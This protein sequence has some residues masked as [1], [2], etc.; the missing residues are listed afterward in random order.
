MASE[1]I[2]IGS[3]R[4]VAKLGTGAFGQV[5]LA[6]H[7][8][9]TNRT[10]AIK[11][12]HLE[13]LSSPAAII[14]FI[15]EAQILEKLKHPHILPIINIDIFEGIPYLVTEFASKGSLRDCLQ[16]Y[17]QHY[18]SLEEAI[19]IL[20]QI[21]EALQYAHQQNI[22][23]RDIKPEN[24]LFNEKGEAL[25]ADFGIATTLATASIKQTTVTGT[26][27]Y[28]AP[29]QF[30]EL[31][32]KESDQYALGCIAYELFTGHMPFVASSPA[33]LITKCLM[34]Q[35]VAPRQYNPQ[36]PG[37]IEQAILKAMA[38][39]RTDRY[40]DISRFIKALSP[41]GL[42]QESRVEWI[43]K[44]TTLAMIPDQQEQIIAV[45]NEAIQLDP[46]FADAYFCKGVALNDLKRH[47]E[48]L[49]A[50]ERA[51]HLDPNNK[52]AWLYKGDLLKYLGRF[53][54]ARQAYK[55]AQRIIDYS[56]DNE[57]TS[58]TRS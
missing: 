5:Y 12:M 58:S 54:D 31:V 1:D 32:C 33:A 43:M 3:Y 49:A 45:C 42:S 57:A 51:T 41:L 50:L 21:G 22:V 4:L 38:K 25:L 29:E 44:F 35:P 53:I 39:E 6:Q 34:E 24:I 9:L 8:I 2:Y 19:S 15:T 10:V 17:P 7:A 20:S 13:H 52:L 40:P 26:M 37:Y 14:Q 55:K 48:A 23:H 56:K 27:A 36:L 46:N 11:L 18:L 30:H 28:M 16:H 47:K